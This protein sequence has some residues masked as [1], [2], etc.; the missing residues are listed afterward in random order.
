ML[1]GLVDRW[2]QDLPI[3]Q[4]AFTEIITRSRDERFLPNI[5]R[6]AK[7]EKLL[8][9]AIGR[10]RYAYHPNY[11]PKVLTQM[12][13]ERGILQREY[14]ASLTPE[15]LHRPPPEMSELNQRISTYENQLDEH[16]KH[17]EKVR[18]FYISYQR[19]KEK[20][21]RDTHVLARPHASRAPNENS[22]VSVS[23]Q[24]TYLLTTFYLF[25]TLKTALERE[26]RSIPQIE[27]D[28][29]STP[30]TIPIQ[31]TVELIQQ[32]CN[33]LSSQEELFHES[34]QSRAASPSS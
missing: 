9:D 24:I 22:E 29:T 17:I 34:P 31:I 26:I 30:Q 15:T 23:A 8:K 4:D 28:S 14:R 33:D 5:G 21:M 25:E 12:Y 1:H 11:T 7:V 32:V 20:Y 18:S 10:C 13:Q 16:K 27:I 2:A 3:Q 19:T 6:P